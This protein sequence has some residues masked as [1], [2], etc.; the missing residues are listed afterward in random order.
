VKKCLLTDPRIAAGVADTDEVKLLRSLRAC[1]KRLLES[2]EGAVEAVSILER[3]WYPVGSRVANASLTAEMKESHQPMVPTALGTLA[4]IE[5]D[6]LE[7]GMLIAKI[8]QDLTQ[9]ETHRVHNQLL[10]QLGLGEIDDRPEPDEDD[11]P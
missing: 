6:V 9:R 4:R 2:G 10:S 1:S 8:R 7:Q 3:A 5:G 11:D